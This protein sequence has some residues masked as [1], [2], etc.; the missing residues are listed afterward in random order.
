MSFHFGSFETQDGQL[1][2]ESEDRLEQVASKA[3]L[4]G[5]ETEGLKTDVQRVRRDMA[6]LRRSLTSARSTSDKLE[7]DDFLPA[8]LL[9][10]TIAAVI[11][12]AL[13][14][15]SLLHPGTMDL[16]HRLGVGFFALLVV[17]LLV[18]NIRYSIRLPLARTR[19]REGVKSLE[20][21]ARRD[22]EPR[23]PS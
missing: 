6:D 16:Q 4:H 13:C 12:L 2:R 10:R 23:G 8:P 5:A 1:L 17:I 19:I 14:L 18:I 11:V 7:D 21:S 9:L 20:A 3:A 15:V 22:R